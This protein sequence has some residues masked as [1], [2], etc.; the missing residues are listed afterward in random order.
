MRR[1]IEFF[2]YCAGAVA[3]MLFSG[4]LILGALDALY[5][6]VSQAP[7]A[8]LRNLIFISPAFPLLLGIVAW[9]RLKAGGIAIGP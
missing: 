1:F 9:V 4:Q 6:D 7:P 5:G 8:L 3:L 2:I